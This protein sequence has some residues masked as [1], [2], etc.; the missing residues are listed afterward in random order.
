[1]HFDVFHSVGQVD[2]LSI[3]RSQ[4][5]IVFSSLKQAQ[6]AEDLGFNTFWVAESHFSSEVQKSLPDA[7]IPNY[8][9]EVGL[10]SDSF[11]YFWLMSSLTKKINFGTA[12]LNIVGGNGGPV[13]AADR[14]QTLTFLNDFL[15]N[16]RQLWIGMAAGRFPYINKPFG[17]VPRNEYEKSNWNIIKNLIFLEALEIF[18]RLQSGHAWDTQ[19]SKC[20]HFFDLKNTQYERFWNFDKLEL[21]PRLTSTQLEKRHF[22]LGSS[23]P[24]ARKLALSIGD[25]DIFNLSFT[26]PSEIE[27]IHSLME[28]ECVELKQKAWK[29]NR[30][31]RTVMVFI[32]RDSRR[33]HLKAHAALDTYIA[34]MKG[35]AQVPDKAVLLSRALIGSPEEIREQLT[36]NSTHGFKSDD[37]LML[38]F[39]FNQNDHGEIC[40][41]MKLFSLKVQGHF[42]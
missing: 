29:R 7:V 22:V 15:E 33:A 37:R 40:D 39:E 23:D 34:A 24:R 35:T 9:G 11:Q 12:I 36:E 19:Q 1:M 27:K 10:N 42:C 21:M 31:P 13:A 16:P 41:Q 26:P 14:V 5:E 4:R 20:S 28:Q 32:D 2:S 18:M 17:I 3:K 8:M 38:W 30:L 25:I 6:F